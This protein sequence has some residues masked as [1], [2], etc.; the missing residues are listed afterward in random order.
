MARSPALNRP[1]LSRHN[2]L[3]RLSARDHGGAA[4]RSTLPMLAGGWRS[5]GFVEDVGVLAAR[6]PVWQR[7]TPRPMARES[8]EHSDSST[9][10]IQRRGHWWRRAAMALLPLASVVLGAVLWMKMPQ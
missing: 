9:P 4:D 3:G 5:E 2:L 7:G 10:S 6:R 1:R 8:V